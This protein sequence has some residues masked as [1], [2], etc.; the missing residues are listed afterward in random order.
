MN[1]LAIV[2]SPRGKGTS[3]MLAQYIKGK[4]E[5]KGHTVEVLLLYSY[6]SREQ[7]LLEKIRECD[8]MIMVGPSY[9]NTYPAHTIWLLEKMANAKG[10]L[11]GQNMYGMIQ[12][13]MPYVHTHES[14]LR[15]LQVFAADNQVTYKGGF[16]MGG[17]AMLDGK[18]LSHVINART[19]VPAVNEFIRKIGTNQAVERELYLNTEM[20]IKGLMART[21][22]FFLSYHIKKD[23]E[24]KG[25]DY[26]AESP[27][28]RKVDSK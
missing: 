13:G 22:A 12:G 5:A 4:L 8:T 24:K 20:K 28:K 23:Y 11:H 9:T 26:K 3:S 1:M 25:I 21:L 27:Y 17:G 19:I 6:L 15:M 7:E 18:N 2:L 16:V 14:G 10:V